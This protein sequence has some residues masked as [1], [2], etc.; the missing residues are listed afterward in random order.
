MKRKLMYIANVRLPTEK[1]HGLAIMKMCEAFAREGL[2]VELIVPKRFNSA[3]EDPYQYYGVERL[4]KIT[5]LFCIDLIGLWAEPGFVIQTMTFTLSVLLYGPWSKAEIIYGRDDFSLALLSIFKRNTVWEAH[6]AK[7]GL[8]VKLLLIKSKMIVVISKGLKGYFISLG[9]NESK[10]LVS[11]S[12]VDLIQ[13]DIKENKEEIRKRLSLPL[14]KKIIAYIGK[15]TTMG[16][17]KGV[18]ELKKAFPSVRETYPQAHLLI[19]TEALPPEVPLY[20]KASDILVMNYP[21]TEHY[22]RYMSPLKLFEYMASGRPIIAP[23]L[24]SILEIVDEDSAYLF[25]PEDQKNLVDTINI[26]LSDLSEAHK[27]ALKALEKVR[28]YSWRKKANKIIRTL[29]WDNI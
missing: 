11:P 7:R 22:A 27:R 1:A 21:N 15:Y 29:S 20:M 14:D 2:E 12:G 17:D 25:T 13:F 28:E 6:T 16:R 5:K 4:F 18:E 8:L 10:V 26:V 24:Q 23:R 9:V 19:V 3:R